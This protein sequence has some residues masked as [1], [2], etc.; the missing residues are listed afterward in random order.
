METLKKVIE[1]TR[2][3][4]RKTNMERIP[5]NARQHL[6][7]LVYEWKKQD[8]NH[9]AWISY[10]RDWA[11]T[12]ETHHHWTWKEEAVHLKEDTLWLLDVLSFDL[13]MRHEDERWPMA[14][15]ALSRALHQVPPRTKLLWEE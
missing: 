10:V 9:T 15:W 4:A 7:T 12:G 8:P 2:E 3:H 6:M 1:Q 5:E 14:G 11:T 13:S